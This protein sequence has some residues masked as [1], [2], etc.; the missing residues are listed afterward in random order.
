MIGNYNF[1][2]FVPNCSVLS[3][4]GI[5]TEVLIKTEEETT[6]SMKS[7]IDNSNLLKLSF[8]IY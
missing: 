5:V 4:E 2:E 1:S 7:N 6:I 8:N 3:S